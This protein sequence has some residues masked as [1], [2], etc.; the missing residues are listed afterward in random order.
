MDN[1]SN[2]QVDLLFT[3]LMA[4]ATNV[5]PFEMEKELK[6]KGLVKCPSTI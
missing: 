4:E 3:M 6:N 1:L 5:D 2:G